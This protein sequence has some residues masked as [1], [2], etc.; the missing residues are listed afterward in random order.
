[1]LFA[2]L[3]APASGGATGTADAA[4]VLDALP[5]LP[6]QAVR[7]GGLA[8]RADLPRGHRGVGRRGVRHR[9][10]GHTSNGTAARTPSTPSERSDGSLHTRQHRGA[11]LHHPVDGRRLW[12]FQPDRVPERE[13]TMEPEVREYLID[14]YGPAALPFAT[15]FGSRRSGSARTSWPPSTRCT[16]RTAA[17]REPWRSGDLLL[18]RRQPAHRAQPRAVRRSRARSSPRSATPARLA[19]CAPTAG[20]ASDDRLRTHLLRD[21]RQPGVHQAPAGASETAELIDGPPT[22]CDGAGDGVNPPYVLPALRPAH[23]PD[24]R[25]LPASLGGPPRVD[26][27]KRSPASRE[28]RVGAAGVGRADLNDPDTGYPA[29]LPGEFADQRHPHRVVR[30]ARGRP[31]QP[32][33][34][35]GPPVGF[36]GTGPIARHIHTHLA[37]TGWEFD[38]IGVHD[39]SADSATGFRGYLERSAVKG[40]ITLHGVQPNASCAP[41]T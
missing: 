30:G 2:C 12:D 19:D 1:M 40:R 32:R 24:H 6:D 7:A 36:V 10:P 34:Q 31:A 38:E 26:G 23:R 29:R 18:A 13:W 16:R 27:L 9:R 20:W 33:R 11:L 39:L 3:E 37:A 15:R 41:A 28:H 22:G 8:A 21:P 5:G 35:R 14:V 17:P 4:A 25:A